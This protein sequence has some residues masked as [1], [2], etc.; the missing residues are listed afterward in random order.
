MRRRG[1]THVEGRSVPQARLGR[2]R[3]GGAE[4]ALEV[5]GGD[6]ARLRAPRSGASVDHDTPDCKAVPAALHPHR[7]G[8]AGAPRPLPERTQGQRLPAR[9]T[10]EEPI[11]ARPHCHLRAP[12]QAPA[13]EEA[14]GT[15]D[16]PGNRHQARS[17][18]YADVR[19][20]VCASRQTGRIGAQC[21]LGRGRGPLTQTGCDML[22]YMDAGLFGCRSVHLAVDMLR[23]TLWNVWKIWPAK[24]A[25]C[26]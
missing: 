9:G 7:C 23:I 13:A 21:N 8:E 11:H 22:P 5:V 24:P 15:A 2:H 3:K 20:P 26:G 12:L 25:P 17:R 18:G 4:P 14:G 6:A 1:G 19:K 10:S 16:R